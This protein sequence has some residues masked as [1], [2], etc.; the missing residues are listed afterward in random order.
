[1][2]RWLLLGWLLVV[3]FACRSRAEV[4]HDPAPGES[5][6]VSPP[7]L[8][9]AVH[10]PA[11]DVR[12]ARSDAAPQLPE[13]AEPPQVDAPEGTT[14]PVLVEH[15]PIGETS[16]WPTIQLVFDHPMVPVGASPAVDEEALGWVIEPKIRGAF[17]W[18]DPRILVFEPA[19]ELPRG[20]AWRV[21]ANGTLPWLPGKPVR[22][23]VDFSFSTPRY[24]VEL[25]IDDWRFTSESRVH[26]KQP[27]L[28]EAERGVRV[29][30]LAQ[31]VQAH[32]TTPDGTTV[33]V[34]IVVRKAPTAE[35]STEVRYRWIRPRETWP[36]GSTVRVTV[37][38]KLPTRGSLPI[39][40]P[41]TAEFRV[42]SGLEI[43]GV[44]CLNGTFDD[45]C[46]VGP[47]E[48]HF[49]RPVPRSQL[50][51]LTVTPGV[52]G[53]EVSPDAFDWGDDS[54]VHSAGVWG[55][56]RSGQS[57]T[58]H[59]ESLRDIHGQPQ[60]TPFSETITFVDGPI[61]VALRPTRGTFGPDGHGFGI[62]A[63]YL[64]TAILR[65]ASL[66]VPTYARLRHARDSLTDVPWPHDVI[67]REITLAPEGPSAWSSRPVDLQAL[68]PDQ[69]GPILVEVAPGRVHPSA[70]GRP[71]PAPERGLYQVSDLSVRGVAAL[72]GSAARVTRTSDQRAVRGA[73]L[74]RWVGTSSHALGKTDARGMLEL[75]GA[76]E[77][78]DAVLEV[79]HDRDRVV[80][81]LATFSVDDGRIRGL[82]PGELPIAAI[83]AERGVHR[84]GE[85][86]HVTGWTAIATPYA[87]IGLRS[88]PRATPVELVLLDPRGER[89]LVQ[90]TEVK[91]SGKFWAA[92]TLP[93][94]A[95]LGHYQ[96][97]AHLLTTE[98]KTTV[99]VED[100]RAP[101]F[102]VSVHA[103][104]SDV[105]HGE[106]VRITSTAT[107]YFGADVPIQHET[108]RID[109]R[110]TEYRPPGIDTSWD[111][112]HGIG[113][114]HRIAPR[115]FERAE[116]GTGTTTFEFDTPKET[117]H[118]THACTASVI[119][120]DASAQ[121]V[122][123]EA[124]FFT[125]PPLYLA[126]QPPTSGDAPH[127][128]PVR[129]RATDFSGTPVDAAITVVVSRLT[130]TRRGRDRAT[131][132]TRCRLAPS[133][134]T[135]EET[136]HAKNLTRGFYSVEVTAERH[137]VGPVARFE[138]RFWVDAPATDEPPTR[139]PRGEV[140]RLDLDADDVRVG[141]R[142]EAVVTAPFDRGE[143]EIVVAAGGL[144]A[145]HPFQLDDG[146]ARIPL[147]VEESWVPEAEVSLALPE[148]FAPRPGADLHRASRVVQVSSDHRALLVA[149]D[150]PNESAPGATIP[151][152]V[153]VRDGHGAPVSAHLTL[154]AVDE[155]VLALRE[156]VLPNLVERFAPTR[157][158]GVH[159]FDSFRALIRPFHAENDPYAP[160]VWMK[161]A[162]Y[163]SGG[164]GTG[165]GYGRGSGASRNSHATVRS[166]T[167]SRSRFE[168]VPLYVGDVTTDE[169]GH[170]RVEAVLPHD[171]T[172]FRIKAIASAGLDARTTVGRFGSG[173]TSLLVTQPLLVR[174]I[175]PRV[176]RRGD[177]AELAVL[178]QNREGPA[179]DVDIHL[180]VVRGEPLLARTSAGDARVTVDRGGQARATFRVHA[181]DLGTPE[182]RVRARHRG[183]GTED[184]VR[185]P[186]PIRPEPT[187]LERV[188]IYGDFADDGAAVL[189]LRLPAA[190]GLQPAHGGLRVSLTN[191]LLGDLQDATQYLVEY[192]HGCL[193][194]TSS[195]LLPLVAIGD[196]ERLFPGLVPE[197]AAFFD[198]GIAR[199]RSMQLSS[200]GFAYWPGNTD[201][202][203]YASA[204]ATWVL[205]RAARAGMAVPDP[206]LDAALQDLQARATAWA[207]Q[208]APPFD[209]DIH[210]TLAL[211]ALADA[212]RL[213]Q[214]SME[215]FDGVFARRG[216]L[217]VFARAFLLLALHR[218]QP[219]DPRI[220]E[221]TRELLAK[222]DERNDGARIETT[223]TRWWWYY[224]SDTR[225]TAIALLAL[226]EVAPEHRLVPLLARGLLQ[227][228]KA[229]R[230]SNTQENAYALLAIAR[231]ANLR[232]RDEPNFAAS[233]WL[234]QTMLVH[235][236]FSGRR[237]TEQR[238]DVPMSELLA[239]T[240]SAAPRDPVL[241]LDKQ[242]PGRLYYRVGLDWAPTVP[243]PAAAYGLSLERHLHDARGPRT[244]DEVHLGDAY[245]V[246][247]R[248]QSASPLT[249]VA[250][251]VPLPAGLEGITS[252]LGRGH[253]ALRALG[254]RAHWVSH[255]EVRADR[256]LVYADEIPPGNHETTI[257]VRATTPGTFTWPSARA[258][259]MYYPEIYGRTAPS[260]L[261]VRAR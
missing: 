138:S 253:G 18:R 141:D 69:R 56:F 228:R 39:E 240:A 63:R 192:P 28:F 156:F 164:G 232:E 169:R 119:L 26:W 14:L 54:T 109:C 79:S 115:I 227:A 77:G 8:D 78:H 27:L 255:Q 99:Q 174:P 49:S 199:L 213:A 66:D 90:Q 105:H 201:E 212:D 197:R 186:L 132:V 118:L 21:R 96:V 53:F 117:H 121:A 55:D 242:G 207:R 224:D 260:R 225:S 112:G 159:P 155:A 251:E 146:V 205:A 248:L 98:A 20:S 104:P 236:H 235:D 219:Q 258:E 80:V 230:W 165:A 147:V 187:T 226:L 83:T 81:D 123:G 135:P 67:E 94:S 195:R 153:T 60:A 221:L 5:P 209:T 15:G 40:Q 183:T 254:E 122:G 37:D 116:P 50:R 38:G 168:T 200:G 82:R 47:V 74:H 193:E 140:V 97:Q 143:G 46:G 180:D 196:L 256:V 189:P 85:R 36:P 163:W 249:Y 257:L 179:G 243:A 16:T 171:L 203:P 100:Y 133:T 6:S 22:V 41:V 208:D 4:P 43:S 59:A 102:E 162:R 52:R 103:G 131:V 145:L 149:V 176:L 51:H 182:I 246:K 175:L 139:A 9:H 245:A 222:V 76:L 19:D 127:S 177:Q 229:G 70:R 234:G 106:P 206:M 31:H 87:R 237:A 261:V 238:H 35:S 130:R 75:A 231:Y 57:Y 23:D 71:L 45:G 93:G 84:P 108:T 61:S 259:M 166:P 233:L 173:D 62:D 191:T 218:V 154:W 89:V 247:L 244:S 152:E 32:A 7:S 136:C 157:A 25:R 120:R 128:V 10:L 129:V 44:S 33:K 88:V 252:T 204:F 170:A 42:E 188:A 101:E 150:T 114:W 86:I 144:R 113:D 172:R 216:R 13:R 68:A 17:R 30:R 241:A 126:V 158:P 184:E 64:E 211:H 72:P 190:E 48:V 11:F 161:G 217:P 167:V 220:A 110:T 95:R 137:G 73:T 160:M 194:Q 107:Y 215:L 142:V 178:V 24:V 34:P 124:S 134:R 181:R 58:L 198:A 125:H 1:M 111:L 92:L 3:S 12:T 91:A 250:I 239:A 210:M 148:A 214:A 29:D 223:S 65:V 2:H 151:I 185:L 202:M